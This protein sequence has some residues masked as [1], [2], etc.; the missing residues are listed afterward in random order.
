MTN[1]VIWPLGI[2]TACKLFY[3]KLWLFWKK[4]A[5]ANSSLQYTTNNWEYPFIFNLLAVLVDEVKTEIYRT[6][7]NVHFP[8]SINLRDNPNSKN[9]NNS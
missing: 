1:H 4:W 3:R 8:K 6:L 7:I 9:E 5:S 2:L